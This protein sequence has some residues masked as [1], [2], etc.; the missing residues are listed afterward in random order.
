MAMM[1]SVFTCLLLNPKRQ[2][3]LVKLISGKHRVMFQGDIQ[4]AICK[5]ANLS[6]ANSYKTIQI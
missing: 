5:M 2:P 3:N 4:E 1:R 6:A